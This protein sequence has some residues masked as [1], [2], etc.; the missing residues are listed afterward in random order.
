L[1]QRLVTPQPQ[2]LDYIRHA[3]RIGMSVREVARITTMDP[4]FL[5]Q[6]K[7]ITDTIT[8]LGNAKPDT[9]DA[10]LLRKAKRMGISDARIAE[11]WQLDT[12]TGADQVRELRR[13]HGL[14]PVYKLVD[15]C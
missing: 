7:E 5:Y 13:Q 3:F 6:I 1:M 2:R 14:A 12:A 15:T 9:P 8:S 10:K 11:V 4:W